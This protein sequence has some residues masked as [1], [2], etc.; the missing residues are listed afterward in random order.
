MKLSIDE[1]N[2][3]RQNFSKTYSPNGVIDIYKKKFIE[4]NKLLYGK[5]VKAYKTSYSPEIDNIDDLKYV[6]FLCQ[7]K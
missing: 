2:A 1:I 4:K 6:E 5:K 7:K 3:P